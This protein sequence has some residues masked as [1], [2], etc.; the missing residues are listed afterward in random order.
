MGLGNPFRFGVNRA[1]GDIY[2]GDYSPDAERAD[3][4]RGPAGQGRWIVIRKPANYGWPLCATHKLPYV[5]YDFATNA[6][7]KSFNCAAPTNDSRHNTGL[8]RLPE[9]AR[10][11]VWY[12]YTASPHFPQLEPEGPEGNGGIEIRLNKSRRPRGIFPFDVFVDNP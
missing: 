6:S 3:P 1:H 10:P 5:D 4:A 12:S 7:G 8:R 9:V 11:D 2:V